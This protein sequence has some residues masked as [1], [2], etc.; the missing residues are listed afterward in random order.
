[1]MSFIYG[2]KKKKPKTKPTTKNQAHR[3]RE[4]TGGS[5]R[6]GA[7]CGWCVVGEMVKGVKRLKKR[8]AIQTSGN[9]TT[10]YGVEMDIYKTLHVL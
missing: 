6:Q 8:V 3:Y 9:K 2:I 7:G 10:I 4:L 1:M 5:Q